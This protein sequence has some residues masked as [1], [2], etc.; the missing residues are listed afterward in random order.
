MSQLRAYQKAAKCPSTEI[1]SEDMDECAQMLAPSLLGLP[2]I[3]Y[4]L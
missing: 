4:K 2:G 3:K 1:L